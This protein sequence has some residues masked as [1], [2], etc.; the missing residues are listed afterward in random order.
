MF[1]NYSYSV[2]GIEVLIKNMCRFLDKDIFN[3]TLCSFSE[4]NGM[5]LE[6]KNMGLPI[7][8]LKKHE[9][10][11]WFLSSKLRDLCRRLDIDVMHTHNAGSWLYG[12]LSCRNN[13]NSPAIV[14]TQHTELEK[15]AASKDKTETHWLLLHSMRHLAKHTNQIVSIADY[16]TQYLVEKAKICRNKITLIRNGTDT[17]Q[18]PAEI[19]VLQKRLSLGMWEQDFVIGIVARLVAKKGHNVLFEAFKL[20]KSKIPNA[21]LLVVGD[22]DLMNELDI[23]CRKL[24]IRADV[25]FLGQRK[26]IP[27]LLRVMNVCVLSSH[28]KAEGLPVSLL[29]A[30]ASRVPVI[31]TDSGG[32][33][34]IVLHGRTGIL[35]EPNDSFALAEALIQVYMNKESVANM[36][37]EGAKRV[38]DIFNLENMVA[39]YSQLYLRICHS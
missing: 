20:A 7:F 6:F 27:E 36:V 29:E 9:G 2:G 15:E 26:D 30:M 24:D 21:K 38:N 1:V 19:N 37:S 13:K 8:V 39:K 3:I 25:F 23:Q 32:T 14:H 31:A 35:I 22:G 28:K 18:Y 33:K 34:E 5:E 17:Y 12:V 10:F 11:D 4:N 16:I